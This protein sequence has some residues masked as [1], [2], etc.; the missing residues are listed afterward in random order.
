[1]PIYRVHRGMRGGSARAF[2][3]RSAKGG[4]SG[5]IVTETTINPKWMKNLSSGA[6]VRIGPMWIKKFSCRP[7]ADDTE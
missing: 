4:T 3:V 7:C 2:P 5:H 1:M 6:L